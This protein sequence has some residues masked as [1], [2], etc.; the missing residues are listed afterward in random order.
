M[1]SREGVTGQGHDVNHAK[2]RRRNHAWSVGDTSGGARGRSQSAG[3]LARRLGR[4]CVIDAHPLQYICDV[5]KAIEAETMTL[6]TSVRHTEAR[7]A[8]SPTE[9]EAS[10]DFRIGWCC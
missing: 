6:R 7:P 4:R 8:R 5:P 3:I 9:F 2:K 1:L 10:V